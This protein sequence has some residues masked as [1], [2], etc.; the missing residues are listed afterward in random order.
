MGPIETGSLLRQR[1]VQEP[2]WRRDRA[3]VLRQGKHA[4]T[5]AQRLSSI[6]ASIPKQV[7]WPQTTS[8]TSRAKCPLAARGPGG[9]CEGGAAAGGAARGD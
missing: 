9:V 7:A 3:L 5:F 6:R 1:D 2:G 4:R 8:L